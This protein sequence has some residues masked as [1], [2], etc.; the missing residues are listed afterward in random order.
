MIDFCLTECFNA[1]RFCWVDCEVLKSGAGKMITQDLLSRFDVATFRNEAQSLTEK[2]QEI[3]V[4][5]FH[6]NV[7]VDCG[8]QLKT[9]GA[10][11]CKSC[12]MKKVGKGNR[13]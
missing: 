7:C 6:K 3:S 1:G 10:Q 9:H 4:S 13:K 11:R 2:L 12:N 8:T 5:T